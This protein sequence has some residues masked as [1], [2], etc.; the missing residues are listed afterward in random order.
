[1]VINRKSLCGHFYT[2]QNQQVESVNNPIYKT[3]QKFMPKSK[4][5]LYLHKKIWQKYIFTLI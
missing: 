4:M 3:D 5:M 1:M 2:N